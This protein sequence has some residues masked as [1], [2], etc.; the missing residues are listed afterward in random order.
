MTQDY[1]IYIC[2][3]FISNRVLGKSDVAVSWPCVLSA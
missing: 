1:K 2:Y 3:N